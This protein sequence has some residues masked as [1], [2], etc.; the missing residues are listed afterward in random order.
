ML[1]TFLK[2]P[3]CTDSVNSLSTPTPQIKSRTSNQVVYRKRKRGVFP[4][5][6]IQK[7]NW[8]RTLIFIAML[9]TF[10]SENKKAIRITVTK[11]TESWLAK[12]SE[13]SDCQFDISGQ[14]SSLRISQD[15]LL[16]YYPQTRSTSNFLPI[17][18]SQTYLCQNVRCLN[19]SNRFQNPPLIVHLHSC[20]L[21]SHSY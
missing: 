13:S 21:L 9:F 18:S 11:L 6:G 17:S 14:T 16:K 8:F 3:S 19:V 4:F 20:I 2:S 12:Y 15:L 5:V 1:K 7:T 10:H